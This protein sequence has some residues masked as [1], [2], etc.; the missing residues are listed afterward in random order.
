MSADDAL[1]NFEE[2]SKER[3]EREA[4]KAQEKMVDAAAAAAQGKA[5]P[6]AAIRGQGAPAQMR[7]GASMSGRDPVSM[8]ADQAFTQATHIGALA[9]R[10]E[11]LERMLNQ[12]MQ[13]VNNANVH[14]IDGINKAFAELDARLTAFMNGGTVQEKPADSSE[15]AV[16]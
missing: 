6:Q 3:A 1:K 4:A 7:M 14:H 8:L 10:V 13:E 9:Q 12:F 2:R 15:S 5:L 16:Q 11:T